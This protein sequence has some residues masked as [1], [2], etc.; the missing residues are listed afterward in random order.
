PAPDLITGNRSAAIQGGPV[1]H[2]ISN[3]QN[4]G[5]THIDRRVHI[6]N[7]HVDTLPTPGLLAE[8]NELTA[9]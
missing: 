1:S 8:Y 9:G 3:N 7:M 5:P 6:E 2:Q 4:K